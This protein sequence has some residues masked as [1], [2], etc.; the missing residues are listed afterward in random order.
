MAKGRPIIPASKKRV[1]DE[2]LLAWREVEA[3]AGDVGVE[4]SGAGQPLRF[5]L[6]FTCHASHE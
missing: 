1:T 2:R 4:V 6:F 5:T 3:E